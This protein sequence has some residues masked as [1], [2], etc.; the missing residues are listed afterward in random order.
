MT[1]RS[2]S[3]RDGALQAALERLAPGQVR[4]R[5]DTPDLLVTALRRLP[6]VAAEYAPFPRAVDERLQHALESRGVAPHIYESEE[7]ATGAVR[8]TLPR[9]E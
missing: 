1:T 4:D 8:D 9:Q 2:S 6:P 3:G 5:P 7:E